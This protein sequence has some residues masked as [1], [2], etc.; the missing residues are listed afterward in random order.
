MVRLLSPLMI[1]LIWLLLLP[2]FG[3]AMVIES[4]G[5]YYHVQCFR[6][7]VCHASLGTGAQGA[8]V[9]VRNNKL[10]CPNCY[11]NDE[12]KSTHQTYLNTTH[13]YY[14]WPSG[15]LPFDC[16]KIA[17]NLIFFPKNWQKLSFFPKNCQW[18]FFEKMKI[19]GNVFGKMSSFWHFLTVK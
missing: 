13:D 1:Y 6:C 7:C 2:G 9:R 14:I 19:F 17:K 16:Q 5:L 18:Q 12:G 10:H 11:S 4:L 15:K 8:D 3:A